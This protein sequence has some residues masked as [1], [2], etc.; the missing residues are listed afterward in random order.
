MKSIVLLACIVLLARAI[1]T[2]DSMS[3]SDQFFPADLKRFNHLYALIIR[4]LPDHPFDTFDDSIMPEADDPLNAP[5]SHPTWDLFTPSNYRYQ[6]SETIEHEWEPID[7]NTIENP[8]C[9]MQT[10]EQYLWNYLSEDERV[11]NDALINLVNEP[12]ND[13]N[14][15]F[16]QNLGVVPISQLHNA[17]PNAENDQDADKQDKGIATSCLRLKY[18]SF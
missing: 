6:L 3:L 15:Q 10:A 8:N 1:P 18:G 5:F 11:I 9:D 17:E 4:P 2:S 13:Q 16:D 14:A 12:V 7:S